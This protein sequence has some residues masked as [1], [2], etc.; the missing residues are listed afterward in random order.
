MLIS[1]QKRALVLRLRDPNRVTSIIPKSRVI[2]HKGKKYVAIKHGVEEVKVLRNLGIQAPSPISYY[3]DWPGRYTP[4][5]AQRETAAFLSLYHRAF[6]LN[7]MGSGKSLATAWAY[8]YLRKIGLRRRMLVI[9]P[10]STMERTWADTFFD[11]F[12]HLTTAVLYGSRERRLK[13][14]ETDV[15][16]YIINP[17]GL[18]VKGM[19]E[20]FATR[21]DI[22]IVAIDEIAQ[23][24]RN[25]STDRWKALNTLINKQGEPRAAWGLTGTP[26]P[27]KPTDAWAQC[28]LIVPEKVPAYFNRFRDRVMRQ[29]TQYVWVSREDALDTVFDVM[30]PAVRF[31]R[32]ECVDLPPVMYEHREVELTKEQARAYKQMLAQLKAEIDAGEVTAVNEAVK[33]QKLV[34]IA[35]GVAYGAHGEELTLDASPRLNEV[36]DIVE[37]AGTKVLVFVPFLSTIGMVQRHLQAK[38]FTV[39]VVHSGVSKAAR[40][41]IF[42]DFQRAKDPHVIVAHPGTMSHGL[43]MTAASTIIWYAPITSADTFDQANHRIIRPSQKHKQLIVMIQGTDVE[44]RYYRRL[45]DKQDVQGALLEMVRGS[46]TPA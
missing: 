29:V 11:H 24:A 5:H 8:D 39:E 31:S 41:K 2:E 21:P 18:M 9:C 17:D 45:K 37:A 46:R 19:V 33:A 42:G 16:V 13:L 7:D 36:S 22:D 15:D 25:A 38:G 30:Q 3:Y 34:Q 26:I 32:E 1:K 40:D 28:R 10:L 4:F 6:V 14:L 23:C 35:C 12:P 43:T 44:R 20:A 27:N